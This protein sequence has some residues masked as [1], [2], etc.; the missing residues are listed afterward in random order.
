MQ[1]AFDP[2]IGAR[3]L[4]SGLYRAGPDLRPHFFSTTSAIGSLREHDR[5]ARVMSALAQSWVPSG[6]LMMTLKNIAALP[7]RSLVQ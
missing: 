1:R 4:K 7:A 5:V 6:F 2:P 3:G